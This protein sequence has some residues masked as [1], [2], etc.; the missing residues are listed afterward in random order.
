MIILGIACVLLI[1]GILIIGTVL[2]K[3]DESSEEEDAK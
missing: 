3:I 1:V 2:Y